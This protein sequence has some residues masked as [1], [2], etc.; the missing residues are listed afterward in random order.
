MRN[1]TKTNQVNTN[2]SNITNIKQKIFVEQAYEFIENTLV[3]ISYSQLSKQEIRQ[4]FKLDIEYY[5]NNLKSLNS[6][7]TC[8]FKVGFNVY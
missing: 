1:D 8:R 5:N 3:F 4:N 2:L 6:Y 7:P